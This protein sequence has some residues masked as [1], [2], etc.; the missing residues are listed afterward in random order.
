M[1]NPLVIARILQDQNQPS[2]YSRLH[3]SEHSQASN[4]YEQFS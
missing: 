1:F 3:P 2:K 4:L